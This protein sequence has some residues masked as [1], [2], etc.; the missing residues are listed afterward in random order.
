STHWPTP[1]TPRRSPATSSN[2]WTR[3]RKAKERS[4]F[5]ALSGGS[6]SAKRCCRSSDVKT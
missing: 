6:T 2:T 1:T 4:C 5:R 3:S